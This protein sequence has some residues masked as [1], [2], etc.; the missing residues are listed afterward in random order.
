VQDV[1]GSGKN[2]LMKRLDCEKCWSLTLESKNNFTG[3]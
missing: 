3:L 2:A 1:G